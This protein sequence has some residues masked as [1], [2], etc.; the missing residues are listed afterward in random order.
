MEN[1]QKKTPDQRKTKNGTTEKRSDSKFA[2]RWKIAVFIVSKRCRWTACIKSLWTVHWA[3]I[4]DS[5]D[6][7][8][9]FGVKNVAFFLFC[10]V[11]RCSHMNNTGLSF[12]TVIRT[13]GKIAT[14]RKTTMSQWTKHI[15][16]DILNVNATGWHIAFC[17][18]ILFCWI[19]FLIFILNHCPFFFLHISS[20]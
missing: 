1:Q 19:S 10:R 7:Q 12:W 13:H 9:G 4:E 6:G 11:P 20:T 17:L 3:Y 15:L 18:A 5:W 2:T 8:W 16:S 14:K